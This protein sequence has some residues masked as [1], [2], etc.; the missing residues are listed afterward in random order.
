M[1]AVDRVPFGI[2]RVPLRWAAHRPA[3]SKVNPVGVAPTLTTVVNW[4]SAP[5]STSSTTTRPPADSSPVPSIRD[6]VTM[7]PDRPEDQIGDLQVGHH[8]R[9]VVDARADSSIE[10]AATSA[11]NAITPPCTAPNE[12]R[13]YSRAGSTTR[14]VAGSSTRMPSASITGPPSPAPVMDHLTGNSEETVPTGAPVRA[15]ED[16]EGH[17]GPRH[18]VGPT[19][20]SDHFGSVVRHLDHQGL[21]DQGGPTSPQHGRPGLDEG[22]PGRTQ[23]LNGQV[24]GGQPVGVQ[25]AQGRRTTHHVH[26]RGQHPDPDTSI[27]TQ[28][29]GGDRH[30][31]PGPRFGDDLCFHAQVAEEMTGGRSASGVHAAILTTLLTG[32]FVTAPGRRSLHTGDID[33]FRSGRSWLQDR[34]Q[35]CG[36]STVYSVLCPQHCV[37]AIAPKG[38]NYAAFRLADFLAVFRFDDRLRRRP[39]C[40]V[41]VSKGRCVDAGLSCSAHHSVLLYRDRRT[42]HCGSMQILPVSYTSGGVASCQTIGQE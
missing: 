2:D 42:W 41:E 33:L 14:P 11:S 20:D 9:S 13:R 17:G 15:R 40:L 19:V 26:Q 35:H 39:R 28:D 3:P 29:V 22:T 31:H 34:A 4:S 30:A 32:F 12:L 16:G 36:L 25:R 38:R 37:A 1:A 27:G 10:V 24:G 18:R 8:Q 6:R 21:D 5:W 7:G 23:R